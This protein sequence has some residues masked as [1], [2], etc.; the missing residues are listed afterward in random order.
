MIKKKD[1]DENYNLAII[2]CSENNNN[3]HNLA[4]H[5]KYSIDLAKKLN[6]N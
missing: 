2:K 1:T 4:S 3:F 5:N 6:Y